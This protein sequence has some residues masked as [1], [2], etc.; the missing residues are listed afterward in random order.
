MDLPISHAKYQGKY[1]DHV[2]IDLR[3]WYCTMSEPLFPNAASIMEYIYAQPGANVIGALGKRAGLDLRE[4]Y[5]NVVRIHTFPDAR[6][7]VNIGPKFTDTMARNKETGTVHYVAVDH[8]RTFSEYYL[9]E[10]P[11][12]NVM[13]QFVV[14][15]FDDALGTKSTHSY[16]RPDGA[17]WE[18]L[19]KRG[20][21]LDDFNTEVKQPQFYYTVNTKITNP[22]GALGET[23]VDEPGDGNGLPLYG[24]HGLNRADVTG[25]GGACPMRGG[26]WAHYPLADGGGGWPTQYQ[27]VTPMCDAILL[28]I[29]L[30]GNL[31]NNPANDAT[32]GLPH[33]GRGVDPVKYDLLSYPIGAYD[34]ENDIG[35]STFLSGKTNPDYFD[36][37]ALLPPEGQPGDKVALSFTYTHPLRQYISYIGEKPAFPLPFAEP[38]P[39]CCELIDSPYMIHEEEATDDETGI[40]KS[41]GIS[42]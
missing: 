7:W 31:H 13:H 6:A 39:G 37:T 33:S 19:L 36:Y 29:K 4:L 28:D 2:P 35:G 23:K 34:T 17:Y 10:R 20:Y 9:V 8:T 14:A 27:E 11:F 32:V 16:I 15:V 25:G 12:K 41:D 30:F 40:L 1:K 38:E 26:D 24:G 5:K 18:S 22:N 21:K 3:L 42:G